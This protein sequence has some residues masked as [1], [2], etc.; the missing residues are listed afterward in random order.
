MLW[1]RVTTSVDSHHKSLPFGRLNCDNQSEIS[2]CVPRHYS[3]SIVII[4][5]PCSFRHGRHGSV[6][7]TYLLFRLVSSLTRGVHKPCMCE[8][9]IGRNPGFNGAGPPRSVKLSFCPQ[10]TVEDDS[11]STTCAPAGTASTAPDRTRDAL[12]RNIPP[13]M[14]ASICCHRKP[15]LGASR[16]SV[17]FTILRA[18]SLSLPALARAGSD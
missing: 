7:S 6:I 3:N 1:R 10:V 18:V 12:R 8:P 16:I 13:A 9:L 15:R 11:S 17:S 5:M 4:S 14:E 2:H